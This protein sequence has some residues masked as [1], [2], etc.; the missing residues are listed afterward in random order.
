MRV[1]HSPPKD[2]A[3][4]QSPLVASGNALPTFIG[5]LAEP[6]AFTAMLDQ[7]AEGVYIVDRQRTIRF[8]NSGCE[9]ISGYPAEAVVGHHC[10][11]NILRHVDED[12]TRLCFGLCP[13][14]ATMRDE[15]PRTARVWLHHR[16]GHRVPVLVRTAPIHDEAANVIG[17]IEFFTDESTLAAT[18]DRVKE[19]EGLALS[20]PLTGLPNRRF[21][22]VALP[23]RLSEMR[24]YGATA[25]LIFADIDHF[26]RVNDEH[27]HELGDKV[28]KMVALTLAG[29]LRASD[30]A[31]RFGGEEFVILLP[32]A[33]ASDVE[34]IGA[35]LGTLV[36]TSSIETG[37][38][39]P[40]AVTVSFG[41][42]VSRFRDSPAAILERADELL[43]RSK[44]EGRDRVT[45]AA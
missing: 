43:Y 30:V 33:E 9:R 6:D 19:L 16:E 23:A 36:R 14:A 15:E 41:A 32:H 2:Q 8:W 13:L 24:R 38:G 1:P 26:K 44:A 22:D 21:L 7:L 37:A 20:D 18:E 11:D 3:M 42:T 45:F 34:A 27:G 39:T 31:C 4:H 10:F 40:L 17:A 12:G 5:A 25:G 29:N 35:R 28:L